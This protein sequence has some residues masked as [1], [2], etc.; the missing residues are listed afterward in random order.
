MILDTEEREKLLIQSLKN[1][2]YDSYI[3]ILS[4]ILPKKIYRYFDH[5]NKKLE[6]LINNFIQ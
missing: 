4:E 1:L 3:N 5:S 2:D 6:L